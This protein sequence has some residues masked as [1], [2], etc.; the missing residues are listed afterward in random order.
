MRHAVTATLLSLAGLLLL[1]AVLAGYLV[2]S[3]SGLQLLWGQV[4]S[5]TG[6]RLTARRVEGRLAGTVRLEGVSFTSGD[7]RLGVEQLTLDWV[8]LALLRGMLQLDRLDVRGLRYEQLGTETSDAPLLPGEFSLPVKI[9][10]AALEI[11]DATIVTTS[12]GAP[13]IIQHA[14]LGGEFHGTQLRLDAVS[15]QMPDLAMQGRAGMQT[16]GEYPLE[17]EIDWEASPEGY[18]SLQ[19]HT[20]LGGSLQRLVL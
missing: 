17:G 14:R 16:A 9:R 1:L 4:V 3:A 8:P 11:R 7:L 20:R 19:A 6:E 12:G 15:L 10:L 18:A 2:S 13:L 5:A